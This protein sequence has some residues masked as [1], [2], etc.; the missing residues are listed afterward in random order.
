[1]PYEAMFGQ[2]PHLGVA[3]S[4]FPEEVIERL[5]TEEQLE[6]ALGVKGSELHGDE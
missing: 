2:K 3:A 6:E 1:M 5:E 4:N